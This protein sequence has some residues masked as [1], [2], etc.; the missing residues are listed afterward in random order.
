M[1]E[2]VATIRAFEHSA[3]G[4]RKKK[5]E[6]RIY[7]V[8]EAMMALTLARTTAPTISAPETET[9]LIKYFCVFVELVVRLARMPA[10][11]LQRSNGFV[12]RR[13][14]HVLPFRRLSPFSQIHTNCV[15]DDAL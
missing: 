8:A 9:K 12:Q 7:C 5:K 14:A 4:P 1:M 10:S 2:R 15:F 13:D 6:D 3:A 11:D